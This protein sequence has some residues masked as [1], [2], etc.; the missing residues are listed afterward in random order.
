M[1]ALFDRVTIIGLGLLGGSLAL[2][3]RE[4]K[5]VREIIGVARRRETLRLAISD[6]VIDK[7]G[8][9]PALGI[10]GSDLVVLASPVEAMPSLVENAIKGFSPGCLLTDVGSVKGILSKTLPQL[11]PADVEYI[12]SHPMAG[13]HLQ[14]LSN[15]KADLFMGATCVMTPIRGTSIQA[16]E[17]LRDLWEG[18]GMR[19]VERSPE[20]HDTEVAWV[21]HGP[22]ALAFAFAKA[23]EE[24]PA[25]AAQ[26][27]GS[28]FRDFMRIARSDGNLWS[29]ILRENAEPIREVV[30]KVMLRINEFLEI[31]DRND[32]QELSRWIEE[33][34]KKVETVD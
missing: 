33:G 11:L 5:L 24:A 10:S 9:E 15:S 25:S 16:C 2:A 4:R 1:K 29:G 12:G 8:V 21:S 3:L 6:G 34:R 28:G 32:A 31:L 13:S 26:L 17:R 27:R 30:E 14:G 22:H 18:V 23:L 7:G 19:V 20:V